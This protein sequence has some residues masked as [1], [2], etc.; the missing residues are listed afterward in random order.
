MNFSLVIILTKNILK[1]LKLFLLTYLVSVNILFAQKRYTNEKP[2]AEID[3]WIAKAR[4]NLR[5]DEAMVYNL[6][7]KAL[8]KSLKTNYY[9]GQINANL[10]IAS[11]HDSVKSKYD[12]AYHYYLKAFELM[13]RHNNI[14]AIAEYSCKLGLMSWR[15]HR[16]AEAEQFYNIA[17]EKYA[18]LK[19]TS[20]LAS[21]DN[22]IGLL[23]Y[24]RG[25]YD[26]ALDHYYNAMKYYENQKTVMG[27]YVLNNIGLVYLELDSID[28]ALKF[29]RKGYILGVKMDKDAV[30]AYSKMHLAKSF[31]LKG[32]I[33]SAFAYYDD[34]L[35]YCK[36]SNENGVISDILKGKA[37]IYKNEGKLNE[38][39]KLFEEAYA[40][41]VKRGDNR[42]VALILNKTGKIKLEQKAPHQAIVL[43]RRSIELAEIE[44][45]A[46]ILNENYSGLYKAYR[47]TNQ[48]LPALEAIE[49]QIEISDSLFTLEKATNI[50]NL[51]SVRE[52]MENTIKLEREHLIRIQQEEEL[53]NKK[54]FNILLVISVIIAII[55]LLLVYLLANRRKQHNQILK[56]RNKE[57]ISQKNEISAA[58]EELRTTQE[59][60]VA[61]EKMAALGELVAG[62]AHEINTPVGISI[63][64][65]SI[66]TDKSKEL[67]EKMIASKLAKKDLYNYVDIVHE[68]SGLI[69]SN[70]R[71]TA[72][73]IEKFKKV[74]VDHSTSDEI[75]EF[76]LKTY[77][78]DILVTLSPKFKQRKIAVNVDIEQN[79]IIKSYPSAFAQIITNFV[80][81]S[82]I[83]AFN[84]D[85]EGLIEITIR[86]EDEHYISFIYADN[87]KGIS[88]ETQ[89]KIFDP[90]F[91][92][93]KQ[94]GTGL[95]MNIVFGLVTQKLG[96]DIVCKSSG[97]KGIEFIIKIPV[98]IN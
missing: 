49:K 82:L 7:E 91:T 46:E 48:I 57:I 87:G 11:F 4:I 61:Y 92:T 16:Y 23:Y 52:N 84:A 45:L 32:N 96:G 2:N 30:I 86:K 88:K 66:L 20:A 28:L 70:L 10:V 6:T 58:L 64:G 75:Q 42:R 68:T 19:D 12:T 43:F 27:P 81:N 95:G 67:A 3:A 78:E 59:K 69:F 5:N 89:K 65:A 97:E 62:V 39:L 72:D 41:A 9:N 35:M 44:K 36:K 50:A 76:S 60:L 24:Y 94:Q 80:N 22:K 29:F 37:L 34:A 77:V 8:V 98:D 13:K 54:K 15:C 47:Q 55:G 21:L 31:G 56:I 53:L 51:K 1:L 17:V 74:S 79:L 71:R 25:I 14:N 18:A 33:D 85:D 26:V 73:L 90:F 83:H 93:N 63:Q 40:Y 38:A